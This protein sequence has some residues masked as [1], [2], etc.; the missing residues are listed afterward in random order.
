MGKLDNKLEGEVMIQP[1]ER[2]K[3]LISPYFIEN[4]E[5]ADMSILLQNVSAHSMIL[6][7]NKFLGQQHHSKEYCGI[8]VFRGGLMFVDFV[9]HPYSRI[10]VSSNL[11]L[12]IQISKHRFF[13][14]F[15]NSPYT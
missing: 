3:G 8:I 4:Q 2:I 7:K 12:I 9:G 10:Y 15:L 14:V 11:Y 1:S 5:E 13:L 6:P